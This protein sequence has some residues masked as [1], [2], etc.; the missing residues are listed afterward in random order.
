MALSKNRVVASVDELSFI[1]LMSIHDDRMTEWKYHKDS[2]YTAP[3]LRAAVIE[4]KVLLLAMLFAALSVG[5]ELQS[6]SRSESH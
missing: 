3:T 5:R 4:R 2:K 6:N 1:L